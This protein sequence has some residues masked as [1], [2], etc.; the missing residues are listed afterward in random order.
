MALEQILRSRVRGEVRFDRLTRVLY[1]TDAS[2][3]QIPPVGVVVPACVEDV[4]ATVAACRD[5]GTPMLGR[6]GATSLAGQAVGA[7]VILDFSKHLHKLLEVDVAGRWAR[8]QPGIV[9]D[10]LNAALAPT[11][12][13]FAPDVAPSNRA[14]VGGM[15]QNNSCGAH[16]ILFGKTIDHVLELDVILSDGTACKV[17]PDEPEAT[18]RPFVGGG[19][20]GLADASGS[21]RRSGRIAGIAA[22]VADLVDRNRDEIDRRFPKILRRVGGYNLDAFPPGAAP[23]LTKLVVGSEGTLALVTEAKIRLVPRP[24]VRGLLSIEFADLVESLEATLAILPTRPAA[25]EVVDRY[26]LDLSAAQPEQKK[27]RARV[28]SDPDRSPESQLLVEYFC[29]SADELD[30]RLSDLEGIVRR[31][32]LGYHH[33]RLVDKP[34]QDDAWAIRKAGVG[35]L[36]GMIGDRKP[37]TF[38]EDCAVAPERLPE[39][40]RRFYDIVRRHGTD[41]AA[42]AHASAGLLHFRPVLSLKEPAGRATMRAIASECVDLALE[43]GG[44]MSGEHGDGLVRSCWNRRMFGDRLYEAFRQVKRLFDPAGLMNPGKIVDAPDML[45]HLRYGPG[46]APPAFAPV[47]DFSAQEGFAAHVELCNGNGACRKAGGQMCPTYQATLDESQSTRGRANALRAALAGELPLDGGD[48]HEVLDWCIECKGCKAEC[49]SNV[50]MAKLKSEVLH[51][52]HGV[53]GVPLRSRLFGHVETINR[54][55]CALAPISNRLAASAPAKWLNRLLGIAPQRSL[56]PFATETLEAW[57]RRRGGRGGGGRTD[58]GGPRVV[59]FNDCF[60][61]FNYPHIGIAAVEVLEAAGCRVELSPKVCCGR[62]MISKGL[63]DGAK[64]ASRGLLDA[65]GRNGDAAPLVALEP[66]CLSVF[67]DELAAFFPGAEA[68]ALAA[69]AVSLEEFLLSRPD[70]RLPWRSGSAPRMLVHGHCHQKAI[71][72]A[73]PMMRLLGS[74]PGGR[75]DLIDSGCCGMAGSFGY[76][77]EHYEMSL[78]IGEMKLLPAVR[79]AAADTVVVAPGTSC[80]QQIAHA[81]GRTAVHPAEAIRACLEV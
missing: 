45:E 49:P 20:D 14:T 59:L 6:G 76:E 36:Q 41:T 3:Y 5:A 53:R 40:T 19:R 32:R 2:M 43:F 56:P 51:H 25:V 4:A 18:A 26:I 69:R 23:D 64:A 54:L 73:A 17:G 72:A 12:L 33:R 7:G 22:G 67:R 60:A 34:L 80:R 1:S 11:G 27:K 29:D 50:D 10:Q 31:N 62:P 57:F 66:S 63:L 39:F 24:K 68:R 21:S 70:L 75:A 77:A 81:A 74:V 8:V 15:I 71:N 48:L 65:F 9:L 61:D 38:V 13:M 58:G 42:Y 30:A 78:R 37:Q 79:A 55:G 16:S 28:L 46:Y 52:R 47:M 44:A 35:I